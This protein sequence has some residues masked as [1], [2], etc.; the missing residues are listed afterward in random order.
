MPGRLGARHRG[1]R[2][3]YTKSRTG[4]LRC[5]QRRVKVYIITPV[6]LFFHVCMILTFP[7]PSVTRTNLVRRANVT[8]SYVV[9]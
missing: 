2:L 8:A 5:K 1:P 7:S 4:C 6:V 3:G 9:W